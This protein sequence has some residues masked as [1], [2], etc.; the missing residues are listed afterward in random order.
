MAVVDAHMVFGEDKEGLVGYAEFSSEGWE[1]LVV[2]LSDFG[3][4]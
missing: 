2:A 3:Y 4:F 1:D